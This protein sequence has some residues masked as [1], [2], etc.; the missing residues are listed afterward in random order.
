MEVKR[1]KGKKKVDQQQTNKLII[2]K[3][4]KEPK[5]NKK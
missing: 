1:I 2:M 5:K 3:G 4:R